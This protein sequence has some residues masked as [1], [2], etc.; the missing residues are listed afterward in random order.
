[1]DCEAILVPVDGSGSSRRAA[2]TA[3]ELA[4]ASEA[5]IEYLYAAD[6]KDTLSQAGQDSRAQHHSV[7]EMAVEEGRQILNDMLEMTPADVPARG[8]CVSGD[9]AKAIMRS[10]EED[11]CDMVVM[12]TRGLGALQAA[13]LGSVSSYVLLHAKCPVTLV[14]ADDGDEAFEEF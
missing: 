13:F 7:L 1:M 10:L 12:G 8:R 6:L 3:I 4:R 2:E 11:G 9:P 14:K 5:R